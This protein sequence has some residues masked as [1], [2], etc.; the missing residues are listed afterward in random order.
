M[1]KK[2]AALLCGVMCMSGFTGCSP[3]ELAYLKMSSDFLDTMSSCVVEGSMQADIDFDAFDEM[4]KDIAA[5]TGIPNDGVA[6]GFSGKKSLKVDYEMNL[7]TDTLEY[8]MV[9]DVNVG[10]K[11]Y[12]MGK[13]YYSLEKGAYVTSDTLWGIYQI[14][15]EMNENTSDYIWSE[16]FA[17]DLRDILSE[18]RYIELV[19]AEELTGVDMGSAIPKQDMS[20]L[21][22]AVFTFYED[23]LDGFET[24]MVKQINGG[25]RIEADGKEVAQ[26]LVDLLRF[27]ANNPEQIMDATETYMTTVM[28]SVEGATP[29]ETAMAKVQMAEMFADVRAS[30][31]DF[32]AAAEQM[33]YM[34]EGMMQTPG[35]SDILDGFRYLATVKKVGG[36]FDSVAA[37]TLKYEGKTVCSLI[38]DSVMA[39]KEVQIHFPLQGMNVDEL[40]RKLARLEDETYNP[41]T[42][43]SVTWGMYGENESAD[44]HTMRSNAEG[45]HFGSNYNWSELIVENGRAYLPL[46]L[47]AETLGEEVGWENSTKTPYVLQNGKRIDMKGK[48]LNDKAFVAVRDFEKLGYSVSYQS[49]KDEFD[50][51][52]DYKEVI[53]EK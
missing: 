29:E 13:F 2:V 42:G 1:K 5:A 34:M 51:F 16:A 27:V 10:G 48:L 35:I 44:I 7:K 20:R 8:D 41:I 39:K 36:G 53:L 22:D 17:R 40:K 19:S 3:T 18:E 26:L 30:Q 46:R 49:H 45:A 47:I 14:V 28:D 32:V 23:V 21:Y 52:F 33:S 4:S 6:N 9:F 37:Y 50:S 24:G 43:I 12:D 38:T 15:D 25:Y 31:N 11:T